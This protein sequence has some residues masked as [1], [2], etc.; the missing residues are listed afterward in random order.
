[1]EIPRFQTFLLS[2][3]YVYML[4]VLHIKVLIQLKTVKSRPILILN[5]YKNNN[6]RLNELFGSKH[7]TL[8][9]LE[10]FFGIQMVYNT[11]SR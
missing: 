8:T 1:M 3:Y 10:R 2:M 9:Y 11:L 6:K 4:T 7:G 5:I